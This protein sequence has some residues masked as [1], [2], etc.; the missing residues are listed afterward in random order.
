MPSPSARSLAP[1]L[2][3][4]A[5]IALLP[6]AALGATVT[7]SPVV[8]SDEAVDVAITNVSFVAAPGEANRVVA[9]YVPSGIAF[10]E[11]GAPIQAAGGCTQSA[12]DE[13]TCPLL[14]GTRDL[15]TTV[16]TRDVGDRVVLATTAPPQ[17]PAGG[18]RAL[19][20]LAGD[21]ADELLGDTG[22]REPAWLDG[23]AGA[24]RITGGSGHD[25]LAGGSA[26]DTLAGQIGND[27]LAGDQLAPTS[28]PGSLPSDHPG[29]I[30][31]DG[32]DALDGGAGR[33]T[34]TY[35]DRSAGVSVDL[36][37]GTG[38]TPGAD[39]DRFTTIENA[40][41]TDA[42]DVLLGDAGPNVLD[43]EDGGRDRVHGR[44]GD[45]VLDGESEAGLFAGGPGDDR[46]SSFYAR[47]T[48]GRGRDYVNPFGRYSDL[49]ARRPRSAIPADCETTSLFNGEI[50]LP[51]RVRRGVARLHITA[52][53]HRLDAGSLE[54]IH[55]G[56]VIGRI[57]PLRP[58]RTSRGGRIYAMRLDAA[59]RRAVAGGR[60]PLVRLRY[61]F[62]G[63]DSFSLLT[64]LRGA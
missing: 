9:R 16:D 19:Y 30:G 14:P 34:A 52:F 56:R 33:D 3:A 29:D 5:V 18:T 57:A 28:S 6:G 23:G 54:L 21:G 27:T 42:D 39:A 40:T 55:R 1:L 45:D 13:V 44:G 12:P 46:I 43:G 53:D 22:S 37:A 49:N 8:L 60:R 4:C 50:E 38:G 63:G 47:A 11:T 61:R 36:R 25:T 10:R 59:G 35:A 51:I 2:G 62:R 20:V 64:R 41:G 15:D 26:N 48:C 17:Q 31:T 58:R 32:D 7:S 24:D